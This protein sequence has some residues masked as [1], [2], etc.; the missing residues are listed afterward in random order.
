MILTT[1]K[2]IEMPQNYVVD[3]TKAEVIRHL[4]FSALESFFPSC[5]DKFQSNG[6]PCTKI[7]T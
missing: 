7:C 3:L 5:D 6:I 1:A 2:R 4:G